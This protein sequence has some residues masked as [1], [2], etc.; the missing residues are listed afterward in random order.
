[1]QVTP[2]LIRKYHLGQC[3]PEEES[4]VLQWLAGDG[5]DDVPSYL[6]KGERDAAQSR[7][8]NGLGDLRGI[9]DGARNAGGNVLFWRWSG[10]AASVAKP[11]PESLF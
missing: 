3:S 9:R 10:M 6:D 7:I 1:M 5:A 8:W 4:A 11:A 2:E